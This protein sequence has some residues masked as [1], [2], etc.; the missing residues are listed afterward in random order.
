MRLVQVDFILGTKRHPI[1]AADDCGSNIL[2][3]PF[4]SCC[5]GELFHFWYFSAR[6]LLL[7]SKCQWLSG[8]CSFNWQ[9]YLCSAGLDGNISHSDDAPIQD[10]TSLRKMDIITFKAIICSAF[11]IANFEKCP[12]DH[13]S[14]CFTCAWSI[15]SLYSGGYLWKYAYTLRAMNLWSRIFSFSYYSF[16]NFL[17]AIREM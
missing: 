8:L 2:S 4:I 14:I 6:H 11:L 3:K 5:Q 15:Y 16:T 17:Q 12:P 13:S 7:Q 1:W 10:W 9:T